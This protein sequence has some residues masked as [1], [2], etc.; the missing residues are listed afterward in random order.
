MLLMAVPVAVTIVGVI[1]LDQ[2]ARGL[3]QVPIRALLE[4]SKEIQR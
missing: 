4:V 1:D 2:P 3:V